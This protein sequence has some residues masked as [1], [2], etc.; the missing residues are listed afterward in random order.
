MA[1]LTGE[2][3][4]RHGTVMPGMLVRAELA[5]APD[6]LR[7]AGRVEIESGGSVLLVELDVVG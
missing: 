5:M 7:A 1:A 4:T 6:D 2:G 3:T